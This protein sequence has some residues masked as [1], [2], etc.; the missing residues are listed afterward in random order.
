[1]SK[2]RS[3]KKIAKPVSSPDSLR[4]T[5]SFP[6]IRR[7]RGLCAGFITSFIPSYGSFQDWK[8]ERYT[9]A[10]QS[11]CQMG[12]EVMETIVVSFVMG[13]VGSDR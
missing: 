2:T 12:G 9:G 8:G 4:G 6:R 13:L 7:G 11:H 1:L 10:S 5:G 3:G